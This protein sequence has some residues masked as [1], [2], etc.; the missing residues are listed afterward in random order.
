[1]GLFE[2]VRWK[3]SLTAN[4]CLSCDVNSMAMPACFEDTSTAASGLIY[5]TLKTHLSC[6][7]G[8]MAK[9]HLLF[10]FIIS[11]CVSTTTHADLCAPLSFCP[12]FSFSRLCIIDTTA[13]L[14]RSLCQLPFHAFPQ[15]C[16]QVNIS[17]LLMLRE[18]VSSRFVTDRELSVLTLTV[19]KLSPSFYAA[20]I[21]Y[22]Y[23]WSAKSSGWCIHSIH[24]KA[25]TKLP[26]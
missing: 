13:Y 24:L 10:V 12:T 25:Q 16:V 2:V 22:G 8:T 6:G 26:Q 21:F 19:D 7:K 3:R 9:R 23:V 5:L 11:T 17:C 15:K 4:V 14:L 20:F 18:S 1:M